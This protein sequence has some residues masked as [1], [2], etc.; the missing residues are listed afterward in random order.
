MF[1]THNETTTGVT[2]DVPGVRRVMDA[3][4]S[5]ALLFVDGVSS[6]G[7]LEFEQDAWRV[8]L[9][10]AG[11]QKGFMLPPGVAVL[12]VPRR[13]WRRRGRATHAALLL[14]LRRH[15]GGN[16]RA[17]SRTPRRSRCCAACGPRWTCCWPRA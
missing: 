16:D 13:R 3:A 1:V 8:D 15:G 4:G 7:S 2:S 6:I 11:S 9:A 12:G 17:T 5:D 14:R 10:V